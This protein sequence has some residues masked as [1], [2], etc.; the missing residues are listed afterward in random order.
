MKMY[1][2]DVCQSAGSVNQWGFCEICGEDFEDPGSRVIL[3]DP[4]AVQMN[5]QAGEEVLAKELTSIGQ[6]AA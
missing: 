4:I 1:D 3:H 5:F 6:D 2:C